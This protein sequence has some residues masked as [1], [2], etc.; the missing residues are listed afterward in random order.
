V[1]RRRREGVRLA[2]GLSLLAALGAPAAAQN[3]FGQNQ[4]QY[5]KFDW[6]IRETEHFLIYYY[7]EEER[8]AFDAAR[9]A[10]RAYARLSIV[11]DHQFREKKPIMLFSSRT[12]FGQNNVTGDLGEGTGGVTEATRHRMLLNFTGDYKSFEHV[13][14]HEMV[15]AF[16]YDI[17]ARG[18]AGNGLQTLV[19]FLP[20]LWFAEGMAEYLSLGPHSPLTTTWM[21]DAALNGKIPTI[22]QLGNE[23]DKYFPY[24][25]GQSL[26]SYIGQKWG[27]EVIGQIMNSVPSVG[28][29][30]AFRRELGVSLEDLGDEWREDL[31]TR[32]LPAVGSM[33][34][35]RRFAQP[36]L[37]AER[38]GGEIFLA[39]ALSND[40]KTIA[41]LSNGSFVRGQVF[42]DL[43]LGDAETG[44]RTAR[45]IKSALDPDF[46]ELRLLYSQSAFSPDGRLLAVTAQRRG[47]DVL[48]LFDV[49]SRKEAK[50]FELNMESVTGPSWSPDGSRLVFSGNSGGITDLYI[51][52]ADGTGLRRL[53]NDRYGDLQPQ[54]SPDGKTIAFATDRDS[55]S[56]D[57]LKFKPWR[58][59]LLDVESGST[60]VI[61]GQGGLNLNPQWAPDGRS[62]AYISDRSGTANV[63]L[64]DLDAHEHYQL[65]NVPG[66]VSALTEFSPAISWARQADRLA[67]TY[68][69][70]AQYTIWTVNNPRALKKGP[71]RDAPAPVVLAATPP[72]A[73]SATKSVSIVALLDSAE[74]GLPDTTKFRVNP[75]HVRFQPDYAARPSI[76]YT[77]DAFGRSV[78][79]GT[80]L[81]MSDMLGNN[82][83]AISGEVNGRMSEARA[84]LGYTNLSNRWQYSTGLS[85]APYYFLSS[86]SL[87]NTFAPGVALED[88]EIT[89]YVTRQ[90]FAVTAYPLD[91]FTR[92]EFGAGFNNIDRSRWFVTRKIFNGTSAGGYSV[93][94]THR[95]PSLNYVDG[96]I[97]LVSDNTLFGYTGPI[98]GRRVRVQVTPVVGSYDWVEYLAD[99]RRYDPIIFN[100]L[101]LATRVYSD[102]SIG[103]DE[104]AFPKYIAR[105]DFVRGYDR[106]STFYLS[107]PVIGA[108]PTNCSAVQLL[109]SRVAVANVE[110]RFPLVRRL[111]LGFLPIDL[112]PLDGLFFY[113]AGLAWSSGQA[114]YASRPVDYNVASQRYPL[115]SYGFGLRLN[116]FNYAIVRW[117]FA[118]PVDQGGHKGVW[119]WSL[120]PSF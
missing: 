120:W 94:S 116:L 75:Y 93:D 85:Q 51:V 54:W 63:F 27:D 82:H 44:K 69:E 5:D 21:R 43:W 24:R 23:P 105:P 17:F 62:I 61:P 117:D 37:S 104:T 111:E 45:L 92:F 53:T 99:Y 60:T 57:L 108:N 114:V 74:I 91:R 98:M 58:I 87:S 9:M 7:P 40:G 8:A 19:Q 12:D 113:D 118:I 33:D 39:P 68:Y 55:A 47:K 28:V 42:I 18:K 34:R 96:Q 70:N 46:E 52:N 16:Q 100:Y 4:V 14:T 38:S 80:T 78:F 72:P 106:N 50:R 22:E 41:F 103:P 102:L 35:P 84:F 86:D 90:A 56:F 15:H 3:Y 67:F 10:E 49:R 88:Q 119:T 2:V 29:E 112:P 13:L 110:L 95:D 89:T 101:T 97:A 30:R 65:T 81:V 31:Q 83:L 76:A 1:T 48:Y 59:A 107:C 79:G 64:Y 20:P 115:R 77:P 11:L 32:L 26:W 25:Y 6:R 36:M 66:A 71:Y 109:G 73:D